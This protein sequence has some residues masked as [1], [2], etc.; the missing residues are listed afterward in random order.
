MEHKDA[1]LGAASEVLLTPNGSIGDSQ[2]AAQVQGLSVPWWLSVIFARAS[3]WRRSG[4]RVSL[5]LGSGM[6]AP[7]GQGCKPGGP[8]RPQERCTYEF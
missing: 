7:L 8:P 3:R 5:C 1:R 6:G 2:V 4:L